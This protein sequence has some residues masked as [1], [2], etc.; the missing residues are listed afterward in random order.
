LNYI[1][2]NKEFKQS[3]KAE[4]IKQ[5]GIFLNYEETVGAVV[6]VSE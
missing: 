1:N 6:I 2:Q 5:D 4:K 3:A